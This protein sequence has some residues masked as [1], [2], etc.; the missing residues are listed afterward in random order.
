MQANNIEEVLQIMDEMLADCV[1]STN[2]LGY[3]A[4]LYRTVTRVVKQRADEGFFE[5]NDR[6]RRLDTIFA[7]RYFD[8][9]FKYQQDDAAITQSWLVAFRSARSQPPLI[10]QHLMLGMNA[11][12]GLDLG[13]ATAE[14]A[15]GELT[16]SLQRDFNR[17]NIIL[18]GLVD[19]VQEQVGQVSPLLRFLD[20]LVWRA[21][22]TIGHFG[23]HQ[24]RDAAWRFAQTLCQIT[25]PEYESAIQI[26]DQAV[27]IMGRLI[28]SIPWYLFP[29]IFIINLRESKDVAA[30]VTTLSD[31]RWM[32]AIAQ[33][34][35]ALMAQ[36]Q[37][38]GVNI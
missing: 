21:D 26:Q 33:R 36:A 7:N 23:I 10:I 37:A 14:V 6:M 19:T 15:A 34:A 25:A 5:D 28:G 1:A 12:I 31:D 2:R 13:I 27:A 17:L 30:I 16:P 22:E 38:Q 18:A 8:A 20:W 35:D 29:A 9:Y 11:H 4:A 32:A 24:A 3:F